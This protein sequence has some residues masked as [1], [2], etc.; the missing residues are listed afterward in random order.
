MEEC[1]TQTVENEWEKGLVYIKPSEME[2]F[3]VEKE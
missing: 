1:G 2:L 3:L